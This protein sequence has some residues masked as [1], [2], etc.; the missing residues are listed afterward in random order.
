[1][2]KPTK[3]NVSRRALVVRIPSRAHE[4]RECLYCGARFSYYPRYKAP[5]WWD[6]FCCPNCETEYY[7]KD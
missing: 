6:A 3:C 7:N 1:M 5:T 2:K 4:E